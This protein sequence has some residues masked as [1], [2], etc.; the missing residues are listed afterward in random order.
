VSAFCEPL[1]C[2]FHPTPLFAYSHFNPGPGRGRRTR[3]RNFCP[4]HV[5]LCM[6]STHFQLRYHLVF[7]TKDRQRLISE[8]L[9][10]ELYSYLGGILRDLGGVALQIGGVADH[11]H[12]LAG[13][14]PAHSVA[15]VNA[16][17]EGRVVTMA[18]CRARCAIWLAGG[19]RCRHGEPFG[20]GECPSVY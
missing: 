8:G 12:I 17:D 4:A 9:G 2:G 3:F 10:P 6:P 14:K 16:R 20:D 1:D 11:V 13:L 19:L 7:S 5:L 15:T 18:P